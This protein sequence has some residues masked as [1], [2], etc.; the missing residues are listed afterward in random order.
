MNVHFVLTLH[1][2]NVHQ[3][4]LKEIGKLSNFQNDQYVEWF[5]FKMT[6]TSN[7]LTYQRATLANKKVFLYDAAHA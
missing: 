7:D 4:L 5:N 1:L 6:N 3:N 2:M